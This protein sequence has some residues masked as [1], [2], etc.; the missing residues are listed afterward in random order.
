MEINLETWK[1][2]QKIRSSFLGFKKG[3]D[4]NKLKAIWPKLVTTLFMTGRK[5]GMKREK[6]RETGRRE[7]RRVSKGRE[8]G[9]KDGRKRKTS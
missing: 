3:K 7:G 2:I 4:S 9:R 6:K 8:E 5:E 1:T